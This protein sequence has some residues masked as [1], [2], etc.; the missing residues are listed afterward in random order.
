MIVSNGFM[1]SGKLGLLP[2]RLWGRAGNGGSSYGQRTR[3]KLRPPPP[4]PPHKGEGS[5]PN[6]R[7]GSASSTNKRALAA[8]LRPCQPGLLYDFAP[9]RDL[10][11]DEALQLLGRGA[12]FRDHAELDD[13][14]LNARQCHRAGE[15]SLQFAHDLLWRAGGR[16]DHA[17]AG[18]IEAGDAD[19]RDRRD[20]G[21][22]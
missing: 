20:V 14:L 21:R 3:A 4:T 1:S 5:A 13:L 11:I 15:R 18:G 19:L 16:R 7:R 17:P 8:L 12:L 10:E 22:G 9:A 2:T 6:V